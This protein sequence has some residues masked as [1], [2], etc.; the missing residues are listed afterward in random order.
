[1][2]LETLIERYAEFNGISKEEAEGEME[3]GWIDGYMLLYAWL[4]YE[5]II[6]YTHKIIEIFDICEEEKLKITNKKWEE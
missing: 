5:G 3:R 4:N 1:M 2:T 6:G